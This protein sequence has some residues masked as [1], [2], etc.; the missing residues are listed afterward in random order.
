MVQRLYR[1]YY[2]IENNRLC[3]WNIFQKIS[4]TCSRCSFGAEGQRLIVPR[5]ASAYV[6][7]HKF[8]LQI[9]AGWIFR[10]NYFNIIER[11][12]I[13][14]SWMQF[15]IHYSFHDVVG[16]S[17]YSV[18]PYSRT[19]RRVR[20][21][22]FPPLRS[23]VRRSDVRE[24]LAQV[25]LY[26]GIIILYLTIIWGCGVWI[27]DKDKILFVSLIISVCNFF[28]LFLLEDCFCWVYYLAEGW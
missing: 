28:S 23:T 16:Q 20:G 22:G 24:R 18:C 14:N 7:R 15:N 5:S 8:K 17:I 2:K 9:P 3:G 27:N 1:L 12:R 25:R 10:V 6:N 26:I 19:Q 4:L 11:Y 21:R 13:T